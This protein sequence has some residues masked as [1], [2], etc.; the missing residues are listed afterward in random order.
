[1]IHLVGVG[2]GVAVETL[3]SLAAGLARALG[4][5]CRVRPEPL[6][7]RFAFDPVRRQ[8]Y[9]TAILQELAA[10]SHGGPRLLGIAA[11]DLYV[12]IFTFV[13][14]EAQLA[15]LAALVSTH[16]L[17]Q[18]FY[19]LPADRD[20]TRDRLLKEALHE[21]GHTFGLR[22][23]RNWECPMAATTA[24]ERLDAKSSRYCPSCWRAIAGAA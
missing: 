13:F 20:L 7:D 19:G 24:V 9:A 16:R 3:D 21:L 22:H 8:Y 4:E 12:P 23:C 18:E 5:S 15:G 10:R 1:M 17:H 6:D 2:Q 11:G 14:G